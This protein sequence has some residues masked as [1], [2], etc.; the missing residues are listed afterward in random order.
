MGG[1]GLIKGERILSRDGGLL[2]W[3]LFN[4]SSMLCDGMQ[5]PKKIY[6]KVRDLAFTDRIVV[7]VVMPAT[8]TCNTAV[9]YKRT[10]NTV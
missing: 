5:V 6:P 3:Q 8:A 9:S 4:P 1:T 7:C 10:G 2:K